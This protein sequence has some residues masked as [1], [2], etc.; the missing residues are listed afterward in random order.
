MAKTRKV[1]D[2]DQYLTQNTGLNKDER[3]QWREC[4]KQLS[5]SGQKEEMMKVFNSFSYWKD[6]YQKAK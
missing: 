6:N 1:K 3:A 4:I 5:E 2:L